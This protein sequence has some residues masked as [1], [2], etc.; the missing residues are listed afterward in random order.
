[1][2]LFRKSDSLQSRIVTCQFFLGKTGNLAFSG[3]FKFWFIE[4]DFFQ[5]WTQT[6]IRVSN[7][8]FTSFLI[9]VM[10]LFLSN[11][12]LLVFVFLP[13]SAVKTKVLNLFHSSLAQQS[14]NTG[15][16]SIFL[17][18]SKLRFSI[19]SFTT[20]IIKQQFGFPKSWVS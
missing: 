3:L 2:L 15:F 11:C 9:S 14:R 18:V 6:F 7:L 13:D 12:W 8:W 4:L 5:V 20:K 10:N 17:G 19:P 16:K 1:M